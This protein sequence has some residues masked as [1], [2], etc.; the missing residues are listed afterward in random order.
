MKLTIL[1]LAF[2]SLTTTQLMAQMSPQT[3]ADKWV[4]DLYDSMS[5]T[6]RLG[7]LFM[8]R[9]HSNLG[10]DHI[11]KV[12]EEIKTFQVGGLCFFQG[13]PEKQARSEERRVG[14]EC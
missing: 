11:Q 9:A 4:D 14:K 10:A 6:A 5:D 2:L 3:A 12:M 7:Q 1:T 13:T 8:I